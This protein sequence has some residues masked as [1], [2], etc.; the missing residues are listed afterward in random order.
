[1]TKKLTAKQRAFIDFYF[2]CGMNA[3]QAAIKAGYSEDTAR[4]MGSENL[5][6]PDIKAELELRY[7]ELTMPKDEIL[8]RLTDQARGDI[9]DIMDESG[10]IDIKR[11][12]RLGKTGLIKKI[13]RSV[14]T[15]TDEQGNGKESFTDEIEFHDP[16]K[17]LMMLG[18]FYVLFSDRV[19][20][21]GEVGLSWK[22]VIKA[23]QEHDAN[24]DDGSPRPKSDWSDSD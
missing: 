4:Q 11:A 1:M 7:K 6:K 16:Q 5:S 3:T 17:A 8:A 24:R 23:A 20:H 18:K 19:E 9:G 21:G 2:A 12:R 22:D 14:S 10:N 13:K 15:Y